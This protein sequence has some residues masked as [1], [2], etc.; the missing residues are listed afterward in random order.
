MASV[1]SL[2]SAGFVKDPAI[3]LDKLLS[4]FFICD[5][6]QSNEFRDITASLPYLIKQYGDNPSNLSRETTTA[7]NRM[8]G[9]YFDDVNI[10]VDVIVKVDK[11][12]EYDMQVEGYVVHNQ[13][14]FALTRLLTVSNN[15]IA[16]VSE[17]NVK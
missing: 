8:L 7:L 9:A 15:S 4:Y 2:S 14:R 10:D 6:S 12:E 5:K 1:P 17:F 3:K 16:A 13:K 11:P